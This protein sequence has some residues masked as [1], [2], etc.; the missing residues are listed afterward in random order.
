MHQ[1][2]GTARDGV[3]GVRVQH[4]EKEEKREEKI[5]RGGVGKAPAARGVAAGAKGEQVVE[6]AMLRGTGTPGEGNADG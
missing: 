3:G 6:V 4:G 1:E 5:P 2:V